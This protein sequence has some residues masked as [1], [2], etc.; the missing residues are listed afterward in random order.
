[1]DVK[2]AEMTKYAANSFLAVKISY[3]NEICKYLRKKWVQML[4][5]FALE[6]AL[7]NA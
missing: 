3:A 6:C 1:M 5:W 2:S 7:I 4:K